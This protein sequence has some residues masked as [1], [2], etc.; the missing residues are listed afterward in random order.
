MQDI[1]QSLALQDVLCM[2]QLL[3][4]GALVSH[5]I[6]LEVLGVFYMLQTHSSGTEVLMANLMLQELLSAKNVLM[7]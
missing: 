6:V 7:T 3:L 1:Y 5:L 2:S 4:W